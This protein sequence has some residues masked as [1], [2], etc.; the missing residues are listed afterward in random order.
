[1]REAPVGADVATLVVQTPIA[2][3]ALSSM[4]RAEKEGGLEWAEEILV[5][6]ADVE[7]TNAARAELQVS[8]R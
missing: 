1:V 2:S 6:K 3:K 8:P 7:R 5:T 4:K